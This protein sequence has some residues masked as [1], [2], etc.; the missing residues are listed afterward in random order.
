VAVGVGTSVGL[1]VDVGI[2]V[3]AGAEVGVTGTAPL[4]HAGATAARNPTMPAMT[5]TPDAR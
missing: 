3:G 1:G 2:K 5:A 4:E